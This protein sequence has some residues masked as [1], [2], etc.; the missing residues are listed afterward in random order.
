MWGK[1]QNALRTKLLYNVVSYLTSELLKDK[2]VSNRSNFPNHSMEDLTTTVIDASQKLSDNMI[3]MH[4]I[5]MQKRQI[6]MSYKFYICFSTGHPKYF[7][8]NIGIR[9]KR[10]K[11]HECNATK[12]MAPVYYQYLQIYPQLKMYIHGYIEI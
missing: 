2:S 8:F 10:W 12:Q 5:N 1:Y 9:P 7:D 3:I 6:E 4:L 11:N